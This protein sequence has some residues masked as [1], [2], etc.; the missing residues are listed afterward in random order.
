MYK[1]RQPF[2]WFNVL[3]LVSLL[4][5]YVPAQAQSPPTQYENDVSPNTNETWS[6]PVQQADGPIT[7]ALKAVP[8]H[9][10]A[11]GASEAAIWVLVGH[12]SRA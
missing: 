10:P 5:T 8:T 12:L 6:A 2:P 1:S 4:L 7:L 3:V 11:D 9:V